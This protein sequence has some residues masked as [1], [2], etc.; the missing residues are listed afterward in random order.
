[1]A[2]HSCNP[3]YYEAKV[4][5]LPSKDRPRQNK[6]KQNEQINKNNRNKKSYVI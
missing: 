4:G 5:G 2:I 3:S 6:E 1:M